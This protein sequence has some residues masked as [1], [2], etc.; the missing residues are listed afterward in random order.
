MNEEVPF[1][2]G[3]LLKRLGMT[4]RDIWNTLPLHTHKQIIDRA[5]ELEK[6]PQGIDVRK[7][8][9]DYLEQNDPKDPDEA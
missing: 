8:L 5:C 7:A 9:N 1:D 2:E 6:W 3:K 4:L